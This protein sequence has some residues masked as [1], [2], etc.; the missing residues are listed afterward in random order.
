MELAPRDIV[1]RA[2]ATEIKQGRGFPGGHVELD[3]RHL[4]PERIHERLPGIWE[5]ARDFDVTVAQLSRWN[6][7]NAHRPIRP[8]LRLRIYKK[9]RLNADVRTLHPESLAD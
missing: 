1:A 3:L 8:G 7:I 5:I 2:I 6:R 9:I 4:G